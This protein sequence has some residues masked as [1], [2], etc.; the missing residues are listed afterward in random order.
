M[1]TGRHFHFK[2]EIHEAVKEYFLSIVRNAWLETSNL[3]K[4]RLQDI[5]VGGNYFEHS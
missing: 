2:D 4:I 1:F 3:W 5:H